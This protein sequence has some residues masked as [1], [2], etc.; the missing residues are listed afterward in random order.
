[1]LFFISSN[2]LFYVV[3]SMILVQI[4]FSFLKTRMLK[5]IFDEKNNNNSGLRPHIAVKY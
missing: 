1:M 3:E 5:V 4:F 2:N